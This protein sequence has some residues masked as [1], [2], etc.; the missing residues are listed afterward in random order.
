M[1]EDL[2]PDTAPESK[3]ESK[4][5]VNDYG[6]ALDSAVVVEEENR[7]VLLTEDQ[8][9]I[10]DKPERIDIA[11]KN[12]PRKVY[13]GM[14]GQ[15]E[16]TA[17]ALGLL[18]ILAVVLLFVLV[19]L[20]AQRELEKNKTKRDN[21][22]TQL[23][24][25]R[26]KYGDIT[27][28]ETEVAKLMTSVNDFETRFLPVASLGKSSLYQRLNGLISGY[29][30]INTSGPDYAPLEISD[31]RNAQKNE[32][33]NGRAKFQSIFP[34]V[35]VTMTLEGPYQNL[36]RFVREIETSE[37]F[38]VISAIELAP[39]ETEGKDQQ[40]SNAPT[41]AAV[42]NNSET[43]SIGEDNIPRNPNVRRNPSFQANTNF[44]QNPN[45]QPNP[46]FQTNPNFQQN[47]NF[48]SSTAAGIP[49]QSGAAQA[50]NKRVKGKT[51]GETVSLRIE[52]AAYFRR[53]NF[54]PAP[55]KTSVQ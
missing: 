48:S 43:D 52:M 8:T 11:P 2:K 40:N 18:T 49:G 32:E 5:I 1:N 22:E 7:T 12:R 33:E 46:N 9:I 29:G 6:T 24:S 41:R 42:S 55:V 10:I 16:T 44:P 54:Q 15:S 53:P 20:P 50:T 38:V 27:D 21:L 13:S 35:Y 45:F 39:A 47:P 34:G 31:N 19:V 4:I 17:V 28:T 30:L 25:T 26:S 14:W 23:L 51:R 3:T 37:Q 36:R